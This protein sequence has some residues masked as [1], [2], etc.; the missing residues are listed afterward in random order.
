MIACTITTTHDRCNSFCLLSFALSLFFSQ[1]AKYLAADIMKSV[2]DLMPPILA[3]NISVILY[4]GQ[5]DW[6]DGYAENS[7]VF[8]FVRACVHAGGV[9]GK[10]WAKTPWPIA[11]P[12]FGA[13][14]AFR[15]PFFI[16]NSLVTFSL[17]FSLCV[18]VF[19]HFF[20]V[21]TISGSTSST[22]PGRTLSWPR[23]APSGLSATPRRDMCRVRRVSRRC[24][25]AA[26]ATS[27]RT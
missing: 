12:L 6:K 18:S 5:F 23:R 19:C 7:Q 15:V 8:I 17:S 16:I 9:C 14:L 4:Q 21:L 20:P 22:G 3:A 24:L 26:L 2:V 25:Y 11:F 13:G 1:V 27:R 10:D